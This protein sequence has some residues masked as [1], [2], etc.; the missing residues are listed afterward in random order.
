MKVKQEGC[1]ETWN[2]D[3]RGIFY[4]DWMVGGGKEMTLK[5]AGDLVAEHFH[6]KKAHYCQKQKFI[7]FYGSTTG[8]QPCIQLL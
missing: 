3:T 4:I 6:P 7:V 2:N 8:N 1:R 5:E